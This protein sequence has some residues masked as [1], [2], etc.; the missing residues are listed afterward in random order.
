MALVGKWLWGAL[1]DQHSLWSRVL[2][3]KYDRGE[4]WLKKENGRKGS[5]WWHD[6]R[7]IC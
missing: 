2:V 5:L 4:D 7:K 3:A 1:N 6:M